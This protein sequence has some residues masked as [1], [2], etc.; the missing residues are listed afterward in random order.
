LYIT[1]AR[2][3]PSVLAGG[4]G[5]PMTGGGSADG[6]SQQVLKLTYNPNTSIYYTSV[7]AGLGTDGVPR[8]MPD[9]TAKYASLN[10]PTHI[11]YRSDGAIYILEG[12]NRI[13]KIVPDQ[14]TA[15][16]P[17]TSIIPFAPLTIVGNY[18]R[19]TWNSSINAT[20]TATAT[21]YENSVALM[22]SMNTESICT[23]SVGNLY[24]V[25][26]LTGNL[27]QM[28]PNN[29]INLVIAT[30]LVNANSVAIYNDTYVYV[31][32]GLTVKAVDISN[33]PNFPVTNL[34]TGTGTSYTK[35][36]VHPL[37]FLYIVQGTNII[38]YNLKTNATVST[39]AAST[40]VPSGVT[41]ISIDAIYVDLNSNV[42]ISV[43]LPSTWSIFSFVQ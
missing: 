24:F 1:S 7:L 9:G 34:I 40:V 3:P 18:S 4:G 8:T 21:N 12:D 23:D 36:A 20:A 16:L 10:N 2:P 13:R 37:G 39:K 6:G 41:V 31:T 33:S 43:T 22:N 35:M 14:Y 30:G 26:S 15:P 38:K 5:S 32:T 17:I 42:Y 28:N 19:S 11:S 29:G 27:V 25:N